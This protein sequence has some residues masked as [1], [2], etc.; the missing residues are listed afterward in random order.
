MRDIQNIIFDWSGVISDDFDKI[1]ATYCGLF[2]HF[3]RPPMTREHFRN[4]FELPY[5]RFC[6]RH[7][8]DVP[9]EELQDR[10]RVFFRQLDI[11]TRPYAHVEAVLDRL[12]ELGKTMVVVSSHSFVSHEIRQYYPGK[13][14]FRRIYED[15]KDKEAI[16]DRVVE[17]MGFDPRRTVF[18]GDMT[19]DIQTGKK[20]GLL[21]VAVT[22]G[23]QSR[24]VLSALGPDFMVEDIRG[25][26]AL[27]GS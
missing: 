19:H 1:F 22:G 5:M 26:P 3:N 7:F 16:I 11:T 2:E 8:A 14:Y 12:L 21:T 25:L 20:A 9:D 23:Y 24:E 15:V 4:T 18:V 6:R 13:N 10:F 17:E 27:L